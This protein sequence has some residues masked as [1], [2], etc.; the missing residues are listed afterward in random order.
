[1]GD[2]RSTL[3]LRWVLRSQGYW[4]HDWDLG[5]NLGPTANVVEGIHA[6]LRQLHERHGRKVSLVGWSLGGIYA[7][8][9]ARTNPSAVRQVITLGAPFRFRRGDRS[10]VSHI[11]DRLS[12]MWK[13]E[14]LRMS[15]AEHEKPP[16]TVPS[17]SVYSRTDG[18]ARWQACIDTETDRNENV[19]VD[20]S[21]TGLGFNPAAIYVVSDRLVQPE[22][23][24][25]RFQPPLMARA[26]FPRPAT[27]RQAS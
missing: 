11:V 14:A 8:E 20:G 5:Q 24:W 19:E 21:H 18:V 2:E 23:E 22:G 9:M 26:L 12:P 27:W 16:L 25:R 1:M 3:P 13:H 4:V 7:R 15:V 6:R 10:S 17:T